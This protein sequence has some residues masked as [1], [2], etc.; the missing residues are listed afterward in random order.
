LEQLNFDEFAN[1]INGQPRPVRGDIYYTSK[2]P[3]T[4]ESLWKVPKGTEQDIAEAVGA[5]KEAFDAWSELPLKERARRVESLAQALQEQKA[6]FA[7]LLMAE[8]GKPVRRS[9]RR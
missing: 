3:E 2:S 4:T 6:E 1:I 7:Q 9:P 8:T 5:G